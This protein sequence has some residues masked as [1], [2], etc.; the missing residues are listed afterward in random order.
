MRARHAKGAPRHTPVR[1]TL[2][3]AVIGTWRQADSARHACRRVRAHRR[4]PWALPV[5]L[6]FLL[7]SAGTA[8]AYFEAV[9]MTHTFALAKADPLTPA[10]GLQATEASDTSVEISWSNDVEPSGTHFEVVRN[11]S[12]TAVVVCT[13]VTSGPC[14]DS[15]LSAQTTY[16]YEV[17]AYVGTYWRSPAATVAFTTPAASGGPGQGTG[18]A[19]ESSTAAGTATTVG[20]SPTPS[21]STPNGAGAPAAA[22]GTPV[23]GTTTGAASSSHS[24]DTGN[25]DG[26]GATVVTSASSP[27]TGT[28]TGTGTGSGSTGTAS[29]T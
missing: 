28:G 22:P 21:A 20:T 18:G 4:Y 2:L 15:G 26:D 9:S 7:A 11:P 24:A 1:A 3:R 17:Y 10:T 14:L 25:G 29:P 6:G 23:T 12:A 27:G 13:D 8:W 16:T 19:P 5:G